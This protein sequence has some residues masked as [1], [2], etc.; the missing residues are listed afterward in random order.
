MKTTGRFGRGALSSGLRPGVTNRLNEN[1]S[2]EVFPPPPTTPVLH[3]DDWVRDPSS[4]T[5]CTAV[6]ASC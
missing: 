5:R 3:L 2:V 4:C 6:H 1:R